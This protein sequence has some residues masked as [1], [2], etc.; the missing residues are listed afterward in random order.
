MN[1]QN[2]I[3]KKFKKIVKNF[4]RSQKI[5]FYRRA[6]KLKILEAISLLKPSE[7]GYPLIR[8]GGKGDGGYLIPDHLDGVDACFSRMVAHGQ[9][10]SP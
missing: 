7:L 2:P 1:K 9:P 3:T 10:A 6:P 4:L 5:E 8:V